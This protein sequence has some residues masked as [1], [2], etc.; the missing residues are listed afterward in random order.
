MTEDPQFTAAFNRNARGLAV[1]GLASC[2]TALTV[3]IVI[4]LLHSVLTIAVHAA[5]PALLFTVAA[6]C[7]IWLGRGHHARD[8]HQVENLC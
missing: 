2:R 8:G 6:G 3:M 5:G 4:A 1:R 7:L